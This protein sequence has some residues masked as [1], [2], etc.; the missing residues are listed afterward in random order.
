MAQSYNFRTALSGF[1]KEDVVHYLEYITNKHNSQVGSLQSDLSAAE[2][3]LAVLRQKPDL[4]PELES[5]REELAKLQQLL[6][7]SQAENEA[8]KAQI[9]E[10]QA[11]Q[12]V[13]VSRNEE[14]LEAYRRAER[15]ERQAQQRAEQL[16]C[17]AHGILADA[18]AK[19]DENAQRIGALADQTASQLALL[20]Q[21]VIGGKAALQEASLAL[22]A[23]APKENA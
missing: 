11:T 12:A 17:Q 1:H 21:A 3:E 20:Q 2:K 7:A 10:M 22:G 9:A 4:A 6:E 23:I 19:A 8:L 14:E 16:I 5:A 13:V 18:Q 15:A